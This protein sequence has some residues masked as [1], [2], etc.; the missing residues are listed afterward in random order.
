[1]YVLKFDMKI[2]L[3]KEILEKYSFNEAY[4]SSPILIS[5]FLFNSV[6]MFQESLG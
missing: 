6:H 1:M 4:I 3:S 5:H 2:K